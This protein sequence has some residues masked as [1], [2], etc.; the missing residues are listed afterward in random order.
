MSGGLVAAMKYKHDEEQGNLPPP[1]RG[2]A[3]LPALFEF[4][5]TNLT[6]ADMSILYG[7]TAEPAS[8]GGENNA[9]F[10]N[11]AHGFEAE[12]LVTQVE[13]SQ[14]STQL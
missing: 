8:I 13:V 2:E 10:R 9:V 14:A 11:E 1:K 6:A 7:I 12:G 5:V 4:D 3:I